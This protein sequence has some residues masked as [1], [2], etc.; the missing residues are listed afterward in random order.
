MKLSWLISLALLA[1]QHTASVPFTLV[2]DDTPLAVISREEVT[3]PIPGLEI[4]DQS[5]LVSLTEQIEQQVKKEPVNASINDEGQIIPEKVGYKLNQHAFIKKF[6]QYYYEKDP[7][8]AEVPKIKLYPKVDSE[9]LS[10]IRTKRIG[11]YFT[12]F[13]AHQKSRA[14]N[15]ALAVQAI[16]NYVLFP[17]EVFSF[18]EVVGKRTEEKGYMKAPEI[19]KGELI[20][21]IGG[22]ICQVS[23]TLF[24]AVDRSG[25]SILER[26][27]HS[28][29]VPYVPSGRDATVSWDGPDF[30]FKNEYNQPL[31][32][33]AKVQNGMVVVFVYSSESIN[34]EPR[35]V[36]GVLHKSKG[37]TSSHE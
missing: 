4:L 7:L 19:F 11:Q 20:E 33:R 2:E 13:N 6:F 36:P 35:N 18:N 8:S 1:Q 12:Y 15:I 28:R 17:G 14:N 30:T 5:K 37:K 27:S 16:N 3:L 31:L 21:G 29:Q 34:Y 10:Q 25:V 24:N 9:L 22:G 32:I 23:S 26:Y